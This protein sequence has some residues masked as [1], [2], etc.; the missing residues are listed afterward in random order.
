MPSI[1]SPTKQNDFATITAKTL[2]QPRPPKRIRPE[3]A[4]LRRNDNIVTLFRQPPSPDHTATDDHSMMQQYQEAK[5]Q[6]PGM[7]LLFHMGDFYELFGDDAQ[8]GS[9]ILG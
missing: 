3:E 5:R 6:N 1:D 9:S 8:T 2:D 7:L 4:G